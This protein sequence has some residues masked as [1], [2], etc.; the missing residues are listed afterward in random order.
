MWVTIYAVAYLALE[1]AAVYFAHRAVTKARTP[2]GSLAWVMFL[3]TLP[4]LAV[5]AFLFLGHFRFSGY[6]ISRRDS[7]AVIAGIDALAELNRAKGDG[8]PYGFRAFER[9]AEM[10]VVSG[11]SV[12]PLIDGQQTF[13]AIFAAIE[14][15]KSYVLAQFYIIHDDE[16][17]QAFAERLK[18]AAAR[19]VTVKLLYDSVGCSKLPNAYLEDL[20]EAGIDVVNA[21]ASGGPRHRFQINFRNHRKTVVVDGQVGFIG[22]LNVGDEYMGRD[23]TF[24]PW[25][26][27]H[28]RL[29]GPVVS[30]LQLVFAEDWHWATRT[31]LLDFLEWRA[32]RV[33]NGM[34][35]VV[36][37]TG[38]GDLLETGSLY[39]CACITRATKRVWIASPYFVPDV[40][41]LTALKLAALRGVDV[42]ILVPAAI[43][44]R[45]PWLAAFAY[46]D[47]IRDAG[48]QVWRYTEGFMHQKVV[49]VDDNLASIGTTNMDNRSCRLNFE[50]TVVVFDARAA[51]EVAAMLEADFRRAYVLEKSLSEQPWPRRV[52]APFA[53]LMAPVL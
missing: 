44:H 24:G 12:E 22:G 42:R 50:A 40:D 16:L 25:R 41:I 3:I 10:P 15:A 11:N 6:V 53:R 36:V 33:T 43:D 2:Q 49:L 7:S 46:F 52:G 23:P 45:M 29:R 32:E 21:H 37:P 14:E 51:A 5:P 31:L 8:G 4:W 17:G 47:E 1:V 19:G 20:R 18:G 39:F 13:Y 38:P 28:C 30:E 9:I 34:D 48:V 26:D 35:A 27:T